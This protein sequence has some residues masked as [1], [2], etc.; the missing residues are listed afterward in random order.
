[1]VEERVTDTPTLYMGQWRNPDGHA[2]V[3]L[4][5]EKCKAEHGDAYGI[6]FK[7]D[8]PTEEDSCSYCGFP[9]VTREANLQEFCNYYA[10]W[11]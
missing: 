2:C 3:D 7:L 1:M 6:I 8:K 4:L 10:D 9:E 5:C 11:T